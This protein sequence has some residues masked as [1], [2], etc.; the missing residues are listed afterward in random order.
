MPTT[1]RT[2]WTAGS[3]SS[4]TAWHKKGR[5]LAALP[6][7]AT[8]AI[9]PAAVSVAAASPCRAASMSSASDA[10]TRS[11]ACSFSSAARRIRVTPCVLRPTCADLR[12]ARA[13]QRAAIG[14]QQHLVVVAEL[15]RADQLAVAVAGLQRDHALRAA[16]LARI[17]RDRRALA[18]AALAGG[19]DVAVALDHDQ[20]AHF[21][22]LAP[23]ACRARRWRCGPS[24]AL[25]SR[26]SARPCRCWRT[27]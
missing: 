25:R 10:S 21:L 18:E 15:D 3:A 13:H 20:A 7:F 11:I 1:W 19:E 5:P 4:R 27:A 26:R 2:C 16:A 17:V 8:A 6:S 23:G 14:D 24:G 9:T 12:R 22:A